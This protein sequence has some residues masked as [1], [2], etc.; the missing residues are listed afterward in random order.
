MV[1]QSSGA[2]SLSQI[3]DEF[4]G[5]SNP[6]S[7]SKYHQN[8]IQANYTNNVPVVGVPN[9]GAPIGLGHF[10]GK[11]MPMFPP[12]DLSPAYTVTLS[13]LAYGNGTYNVSATVERNGSGTAANAFNKNGTFWQINPYTSATSTFSGVV[14]PG[15]YVQI[16]LPHTIR[17]IRYSITTMSINN[18]LQWALGGSTNGTSW[19]F[20][21]QRSYATN[22]A[23]NTTYY[24]DVSNP[25][26]YSHFRFVYMRSTGAYPVLRGLKIY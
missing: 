26:L 10:L 20:L 15:D 14:Y 3:R 12:T 24:Y 13:G 21:D 1:L 7:L 17:A 25:G 9:V 16:K 2:I 23:S 22:L 11:S 18:P 19:T 8:V 6:V 4:G 5:G